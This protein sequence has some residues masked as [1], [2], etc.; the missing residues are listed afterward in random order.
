MMTRLSGIHAVQ[1]A[2]E[3]SPQKISQAWVDEQRMDARLKP[4]L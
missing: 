4:L 1:A 3:Y 2:L